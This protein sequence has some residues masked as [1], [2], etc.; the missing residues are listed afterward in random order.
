M[1]ILETEGRKL[2][3]EKYDLEVFGKRL[4]DIIKA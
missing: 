3:F 4:Y 2:I 1:A